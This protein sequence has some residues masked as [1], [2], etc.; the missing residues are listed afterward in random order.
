MSSRLQ[1]PTNVCSSAHLCFSSTKRLLKIQM[2]QLN[3]PC[4]WNEVKTPLSDRQGAVQFGGSLAHTVCPRGGSKFCMWKFTGSLGSHLML[5]PSQNV[6]DLGGSLKYGVLSIGLFTGCGPW[7]KW[8]IFASQ[9]GARGMAAEG[10]NW[11]DARMEK[12]FSN[13]NG[14]FLLT[15]MK[16]RFVLECFFCAWVGILG[17]G[18]AVLGGIPCRPWLVG[19][20]PRRE[21]CGKKSA[22]PGCIALSGTPFSSASVQDT[23]SRLL[24]EESHLC[25]LASFFA[26]FSYI[27]F[28]SLAI[29]FFPL[30]WQA[31]VNFT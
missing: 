13:S 6:T 28:S 30:L 23:F 2:P 18:E 14:L 25:Y 5:T 26:L 22:V 20:G 1:E 24:Q 27:P 4:F 7:E 16:S 12:I 9:R 3:S 8:V 10:E 21:Q 17:T 11:Q 29:H 15:L 19:V 31:S